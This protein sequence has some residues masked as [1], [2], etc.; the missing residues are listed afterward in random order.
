MPQVAAPALAE[1]DH[2]GVAAVDLAHCQP[3]RF[4][5][6]GHGDEMHVVGHEA[7]GPDG[8]PTLFTPLRHELDVGSVVILAEENPLPAG[9]RVA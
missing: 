2:A 3:Q 4:R 9:Y 7:I 5:R 8:H 1:V 6:L